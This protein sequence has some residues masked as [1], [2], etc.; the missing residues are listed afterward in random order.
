MPLPDQD[1]AVGH[2]FGL[3]LDGV[4]MPLLQME[5]LVLSV[6]GL[7]AGEDTAA[8]AAARAVTL[9]RPLTRE[10]TFTDWAHQAKTQGVA[11]RRSATVVVFAT[12]GTP[13]ARYH[14]E[15]AWPSKLEIGSLTHG[16]D[17]VVVERLTL[18]YDD[19]EAG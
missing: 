15:N 11:S 12:D 3:E 6:F 19:V 17:H 16:G 1:A 4:D 9:V 8:R 13:V 14:L 18:T 10:S 7:E 2:S 5:N